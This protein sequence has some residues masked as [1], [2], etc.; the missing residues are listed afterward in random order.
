[1]QLL[2]LYTSDAYLALLRRNRHE[3][4][5]LFQDLLIGVTEFFRDPSAFEALGPSVIPTILRGKDGGTPLRIW[6][7]G[8]ASGEE[9]YSIAI[10]IHEYLVQLDA[11]PPV[12]I[13][14]TDID[15]AALNVA[16]RGWYD[17]SITAHVGPERLSRYF[18]PEGRGYRVSQ[19]V[20]EQ[21]LFSVHN[22][23]SDPPFGRMDLIACRNLL[24]YFDAKL[25]RQL[26]PLFHY[27]LAPDGYLF[28]GLAESVVGSADAS[29]LFRVI[30]RQ[31]RIYQRKERLLQPQI[32]FPW[33]SARRPPMRMSG[34][35]PHLQTATPGVFGA[36]IERILLRDYAPTALVIDPQGVLIHLS[37]QTYP[38]LS[39]PP[40]APTA[41]L[42]D[43]SHPDLRLPLRAAIRTASQRLTAVVRKDVTLAV[44]DGQLHLTLTVRHLREVDPEA[45]LLLVIL[46]NNGLLVSEK[47]L[48]EQDRWWNM[49]IQPYLTLAKRVDGVVVTFSDITTLKQAEAMLQNAHDEL[50]RQV[51]ERTN[52][53]D[54]ANATLQAQLAVLA[55]S[56][57]TRRQLL[58]QLVTAQEEER[59]HIARELHDQLAQDLA[60][61]ILGLKSVQDQLPADTPGSERIAQIQALAI[62]ISQVVRNLAV[63]LRPS[64]LDDLGLMLALRNYVEQ[65]SARAHIAT[66]LHTSGLDITRL[67]LAVETTI[68]RLVQEALTN[69]LKH[70]Q[71]SEVSLI[72]ERHGNEVRVIIEDDGVGFDLSACED[73]LADAQKLGLIGMRER[74]TLLDGTLTIE[75]EPGSGTSIFAHIPLTPLK[76]E[77]NDT[78]HRIPGR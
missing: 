54:I 22:L 19:T 50:E 57:Q 47:L 60:G 24:I 40:G 36:V 14:A 42:F 77:Y 46:Q 41:N 75:S 4:K 43:M 65:W 27:A 73:A 61:L 10:M 12:Q 23:I 28:L 51:A 71:A 55:Q 20:R 9:A 2:H 78:D 17:A 7:P 15:E 39:V 25:Q 18:V 68:Y 26:I 69:V 11:R 1:M 49:Y 62:Q 35:L 13:F 59:R 63:Q 38:Y 48:A 44:A 72:V 58:Q 53:L 64:V 6:V 32:V 70:A 31:Y 3:V 67:P 76:E 21:C 34:T 52:E 66:D 29:D 37:G 33:A 16:R 45:G 30:D 56:E 8:C 5:L 74:V